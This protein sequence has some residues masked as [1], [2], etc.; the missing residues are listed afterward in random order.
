[1]QRSR[2]ARLALELAGVDVTRV[3]LGVRVLEAARSYVGDHL[4]GVLGLLR[5]PC[6]GAQLALVQPP[7]IAETDGRRLPRILLVEGAP[8]FVPA[9]AFVMPFVGSPNGDH[10]ANQPTH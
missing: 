3:A 10:L 2:L 4:G 9:P 8:H 6:A 7:Q 1:M 5:D